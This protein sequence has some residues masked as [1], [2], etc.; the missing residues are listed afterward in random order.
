[1]NKGS[2]VYSPS[3]RTPSGV[4]TYIKPCPCQKGIIKNDQ[5]PLWESFPCFP[6]NSSQLHHWPPN[7]IQTGPPLPSYPGASARHSRPTPAHCRCGTPAKPLRH[8]TR[9]WASN[10]S[11]R[12]DA[13]E[14]QSIEEGC[15]SGWLL[16]PGGLV[17]S[18]A[19]FTQ[20]IL[21]LKGLLNLPVLR[22][23]E[24]KDFPKIPG[25]VNSSTW[26]DPC[27]TGQESHFTGLGP[28]MA[29]SVTRCVTKLGFRRFKL[30]KLEKEQFRH[31]TG[32]RAN[33]YIWVR[34]V[35]AHVLRWNGIQSYCWLDL[36]CGPELISWI[37]MSPFH[38]QK[39]DH[40]TT[41]HP[42]STEL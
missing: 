25:V 34:V 20:E 9:P 31:H 1:M 23:L 19:R 36:E 32:Q 39:L 10:S 35:G 26:I 29:G 28:H 14:L 37:K 11:G 21:L 18:C 41:W 16:A 3:N 15:S 33:Q 42:Q 4:L 22:G 5:E 6:P 30:L 12:S 7:T 24:D 38:G 40:V 17:W 2:R 27:P 13:S 8:W